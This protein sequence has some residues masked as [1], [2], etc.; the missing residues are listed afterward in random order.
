[1]KLLIIEDEED[2]L[3]A[4]K[5]GFEQKGHVVDTAA[6]G[7]E[8]AGLADAHDYDVVILDLSLPSMDGLDVLKH[9]RAHGLE[10]RVLILS[11]RSTFE[12]RVEGLD[13]GADDYLVKPFDF[14][15]LEARVRSLLRRGFA[16]DEVV[17]HFGVFS[18]DSADHTLRAGDQPVPLTPKEYDIL[19]YLLANHG[20]PVTPEDLI[21]H[22]WQ[23]DLSMFSNSVKVHMSA[24]RRKLGEHSDVDHIIHIRGAGYAIPAVRRPGM[25]DTQPSQ[26]CARDVGQVT[27]QAGLGGLSPQGSM[28]SDE[29]TVV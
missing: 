27:A 16:N 15:E 29:P 12:Q 9:I 14:G 25:T 18:L 23:S 6:D 2:L 4:L 20:N 1:M 5:R 7:R 3:D 28:A 10:Q 17:F 8:G 13:L 24:L 11:A 22:V 19:E 21:E 26:S